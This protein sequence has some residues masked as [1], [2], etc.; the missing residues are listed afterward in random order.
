MSLYENDMTYDELRKMIDATSPRN[1]AA[2]GQRFRP[3]DYWQ[4]KISKAV[5]DALEQA[6]K[7]CEQVLDA[8]TKAHMA[9][10][11]NAIHACIEAIRALPPAQAE[12]DELKK[13]TGYQWYSEALER[14]EAAEQQRDRLAVA[15]NS[16]KNLHK[17]WQNDKEIAQYSVK[18]ANEVLKELWKECGK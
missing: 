16:I 6:A 2:C 14:A 1:C 12:R 10:G 18:M 4:R 7:V 8:R 17:Y 11:F 3:D 5:E 9:H 15:L 13:T